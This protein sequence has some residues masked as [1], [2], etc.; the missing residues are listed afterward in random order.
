MADSVEKR[1]PLAI[2][3]FFEGVSTIANIAIVNAGSICAVDLSA[4]K[5]ARS[6]I[7]LFNRIGREQPFG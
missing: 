1:G 4:A 6:Q 2:M 7:E 5:R 3:H